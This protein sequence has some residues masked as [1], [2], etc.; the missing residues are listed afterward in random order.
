M[1]KFFITG[2]LLLSGCTSNEEAKKDGWLYMNFC[3][4]PTSHDCRK[5]TE[6]NTAYLDEL[7]NEGL[8]KLNTDGTIG[9]AQAEKVDISKDGLVYEFHL[10]NTFWS[11]GDPVTAEDFARS[12]RKCLSP[13]FVSPFC[14]YFYSIKNARLAKKGLVP[15]DQVGID[16][17]SPKCLRVTLEHP[18]S[19]FL[20]LI[21][22]SLALPFRYKNEDESNPKNLL[23]NGPFVISKWKDG[24]KLKKI[25]LKRNPYYASDTF[26]LKGIDI[27]LIEDQNTAFELFERGQLDFIG[28]PY[29]PLSPTTLETMS[30]DSI[31]AS[32]TKKAVSVSA[33]NF[34]T[35]RFPLN[36]VHIRRALSYAIDKE[37]LVKAFSAHR[38]IPAYSLVPDGFKPQGYTSFTKGDEE[39]AKEH[40]EK[41]LEELGITRKKFPKLTLLYPLSADNVII[42]KIAQILQQN[43]KNVLGI[44]I[45]LQTCDLKVVIAAL[46][47]KEFDIGLTL[48]DAYYPHPLSFLERF[49]DGDNPKNYT[50]WQNKEFQSAM[51]E[52]FSAIDKQEELK[53]IIRAETILAEEAPLAPVIFW[54]FSVFVDS[55]IKGLEIDNAGRAHLENVKCVAIDPGSAL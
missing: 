11:N 6:A 38:F 36:N 5:T 3:R 24:A 2:A 42:Q 21:T 18:A 7:L 15:L 51:N 23:S 47:K 29:S 53:A 22:A 55:R 16:V 45:A 17:I 41:G 25:L 12:W 27:S 1:K 26:P 14:Y 54:N 4:E 49:I 19:N 37:L 28:A 35:W 33:C 31:D 39:L 13:D 20:A 8:I 52:A 50:G 44:E 43:W 46:A 34:N 9:P 48:W 40:F 10:K 32:I 30:A